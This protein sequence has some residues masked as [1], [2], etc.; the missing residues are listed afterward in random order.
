MRSLFRFSSLA[1]LAGIATAAILT[2]AAAKAGLPETPGMPALSPWSPGPAPATSG[3]EPLYD[4]LLDEAG[5]LLRAVP[6]EEA[7]GWKRELKT[8][9]ASLQRRAWL[10]LRIGEWELGNDEPQRAGWHFRR[11]RKITTESDPLHG[12]A[13][14]AEAAALH[15]E[16]AYWEARDAFRKLLA[17]QTM[18]GFS[19]R[20]AALWLRHASACAGYHDERKAM[21]ITTP[22]RLDPLCGAAGLAV[23]LRALGLPYDRKTVLGAC[24]VTGVGSSMQD[25]VDACEKLGVSGR[26]ITADE[27]GLK[28]LPKPLVAYVTR[29]H[30][31]TVI[32]A[33]AK[34]VSYICSECGPWPGGRRDVTWKQWR[35]L[36]PGLYLSVV[37]RGS[38]EDRALEQVLA[39]G[40][41]H[42]AEGSKQKADTS[43]GEP[44]RLASAGVTPALPPSNTPTLPYSR[45]A[46][47]QAQ[48]VTTLVQ[49]LR[50]H[51]NLFLGF[52]ATAECVG[53]PEGLPCGEGV[54][55]PFAGGGPGKG[56]GFGA[57]PGFGPG[58]LGGPLGGW[59]GGFGGFGG[60][61][62]AHGG[63]SWG[64]PVNLATGEEEYTP[65][66]DITVYNPKGPA[67]SW[68]RQYRS[69]RGPDGHGNEA[70]STYQQDD[71]GAG[72]STP[73]NV[74]VL[75]PQGGT[76]RPQV[77]QGGSALFPAVANNAPAGGL[78]WDIIRAGNTVASSS[79]PNGWSVSYVSPPNNPSGFTVGAP[80]GAASALDY[81][82][83]YTAAGMMGQVTAS[84]LFD[85]RG[86]ADAPQGSGTWMSPTGQDAPGAGLSWDVRRG[87]TVI[88]T[89][90]EP[91]GW[92]VSYD[93]STNRIQ[94]TPPAAAFLATNYQVRLAAF[95]GPARS[96]A[97]SVIPLRLRPQTG[98]KWLIFPNGSRIS[99]TAGAV[100]T[101]AAP[102]V[103]CPARPGASFFVEWNYEAANTCGRFTVRFS[104]RSRWVT[105][106][107]AKR[108]AG[109]NSLMF[110][111]AQQA[112]SLGNGLNFWYTPDNLTKS[113]FPLLTAVTD[114]VS[115]STLLTVSRAADGTGNITGV[116]DCYGRSV[117]YHTDTYASFLNGTIVYRELDQVSLIVPTGTQSPPLRYLYGYTNL[118]N[119]VGS[120]ALVP[121]L[122]SIT[123]PSP[124]GT[125]T[126]T[127]TITYDPNTLLVTRLTDAN[128]FRTDISEVN[129]NQTKVSRR[130][131]QGNTVYEYTVGF[132][133][134]MSTTSVT[135]GNGTVIKSE[136]YS[137][138]NNPYRPSSITDGNGR[139]TQLWW[140][141]YGNLLQSRSP[142][143]VDT[144]YTWDYSVWPLGRLM[145]V[146]EGSKTSTTL[147][148]YE[149]SGLIQTI[150]T[151][152]PGTSGTGQRVTTTITWDTLRNP[153][154]I[155]TPGNNAASTL[156]TTLNYTTDG[157]YSQPAAVGQPLTITNHLGKVWHARYDSRGNRTAAWDPL[158]YRTDTTFNLADQPTQTQYP[159][160]GQT[161]PGR[162]AT[163][164]T[165]LY[166]GGPATITRH[167]DESGVLVRQVNTALGPEGETLN[168]TGSTEPFALEYDA[169]YRVKKL[170]DGN[171]N[172]TSYSFNQ[173]GRCSA[174]SYPGGGSVTFPLYDNMGNVLRRI[175]GR[176]IQ[177][178]YVRNDA[179]DLLTAVQYPAFPALNVTIQRDVYGRISSRADGTGVEGYAFDDLDET[180]SV[181]T[182]YTGLPARTLAY[183][184]YA[185]GSRQSMSTPAGNFTYLYDAAQRL[186]S[187]TNPYAETSS[188]TYRDNDWLLTQTLANQVTSTYTTNAWG[189]L[190][191]LTTRNSG[192]QILSQFTSMLHDAVGNRTSITANI[193]GVPQYSG[194]TTYQY[195][196][197]DE[198][199]Q[200]QSARGGGYLSTFGY[201][202]AGNSTTWKGAAKVFNTNNQ[203]TAHT[204]D[205]NGNPTV[206]GGA[207]MTWSPENELTAVGTTLTAGYTGTSK[208]AW[209]QASSG[210]T[211]FLYDHYY[212]DTPLVEMDV[213]GVVTAVNTHGVNGLTS[214]RSAG[215]STFYTFDPQGSVVQRLDS[216]GNM[217]TS[218]M[219]DAHGVGASS[220]PVADP[221][222]YKAQHGYY[223]DTE[224]GLYLLSRR[225]LDPNAGRFLGRDALG[226]RGGMN[227]YAY[228]RNNP[229]NLMDPTGLVGEIILKPGMGGIIGGGLAIPGVREG[230]I[231]GTGGL[232]G[233]EIGTHIGKRLRD[234]WDTRCDPKPTPPPPRR[235]CFLIDEWY[236]E[237]WDITYCTYF[238]PETGRYIKHR[239]WGQVECLAEIP[240][241]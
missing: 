132:N 161:G 102:T 121:F 149:P 233:W 125:G 123:V 111:L 30:F 226:Y 67:V 36:E 127:A 152:L 129:A 6:A 16:G 59:G 50:G 211:Y 57:G 175:D 192:G 69:L 146:Q 19:R 130:D 202:G 158:G 93:M 227:L 200:E 191:D 170:Y 219:F 75:D 56:G 118:P 222:G 8:S 131:P 208:R 55:C 76:E 97:F 139:V 179:E 241:V 90:V 182:T 198:L 153:L 45:T 60:G 142:R 204:W 232:I 128:G 62:G 35:A 26:A 237:M 86:A 105:T 165:Y 171:N 4:T 43:R 34:G 11:V 112:D 100:P 224:T 221:F 49:L 99:F 199:T 77:P 135:D 187:L 29:D 136:A 92:G 42:K 184:F 183:A 17:S 234:W 213:A 163:V 138:P 48:N 23:C 159:P 108:L 101:A 133:N 220:G 157:G 27:E 94:V 197:K 44:L 22:D 46:G 51:V 162:A 203:D 239:L 205:L 196:T 206:Y 84:A 238:C 169:A 124:T 61:R 14:Y 210:R 151:P 176:G 98:T 53:K 88:A 2:A 185:D 167:Y 63:P 7:A 58:A 236:N 91:R 177:T 28:R 21:G 207:A 82:V 216:G 160:T 155:T 103:V 107:A 87:G 72:W 1:V 38:V 201:D 174:V 230:I 47:L 89:S 137:D 18:T 140:D 80:A 33:S 150:N 223:R 166:T 54:C 172:A 235:P 40:R 188:W 32:A 113:A 95:F 186:V 218:M 79:S 9:A 110:A 194:L 66:P 64:D 65:A 195:N 96:A 126:S 189:S 81:E 120:Q 74:W 68:S 148:Y 10:H 178:D 180:T 154:T 20:R 181:T 173:A 145:A 214:R 39:E 141:A 41:G 215:S 193:P 156:T 144:V 229:I 3:G 83:R 106:T 143:L 25:L 24:R 109:G 73:Y 225:Y 31:I 122:T 240:D 12:L 78:T 164:P 190:T 85:V 114:A 116:H 115:G 117:Y 228:A 231:I 15:T 37:R 104:D 212:P 119:D 217:L 13:A 71:F 147:T 52:L 70:L 5:H 209:K 168:V 134:D